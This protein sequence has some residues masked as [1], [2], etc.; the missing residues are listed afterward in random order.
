M[1]AGSTLSHARERRGAKRSGWMES[2][3]EALDF[4]L[5]ATLRMFVLQREPAHRL[6][7]T[8]LLILTARFKGALSRYLATL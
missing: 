1:R 3:E 2:G 7:I 4:T 5:A 8:S 6:E